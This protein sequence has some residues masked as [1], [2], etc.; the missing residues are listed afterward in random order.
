MHCH[1]L[2][3]SRNGQGKIS[4][5]LQS[6]K[7]GTTKVLWLRLKI[8][9]WTEAFLSEVYNFYC[10][11]NGGFKLESILCK[12]CE[13]LWQLPADDLQISIMIF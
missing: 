7:N 4:S 13:L 5:K 1:G 3:T 11:Q 12:Q 8:T 6:R 2:H 9:E 10:W